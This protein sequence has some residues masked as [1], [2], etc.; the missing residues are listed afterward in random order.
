MRAPPVLMLMVILLMWYPKAP[1]VQDRDFVELFCG[2]MEA[3]LR[4]TSLDIELDPQTMDFL[5]PAGAVIRLDGQYFDRM[6][7][8]N[9]RLSLRAM[10]FQAE[11]LDWRLLDGYVQWAISE[12]TYTLEQRKMSTLQP[13][14]HYYKDSLGVQRRIGKRAEL[15][16]SQN[17]T[18]NFGE[19]LAGAFLNLRAMGKKSAAADPPEV[20]DVMAMLQSKGLLKRGASEAP[21]AERS[22]KELKVE[23]RARSKRK[24]ADAKAEAEKPDEE[25]PP[26]KGKPSKDQAGKNPTEKQEEPNKEQPQEK[27]PSKEKS[28]E[29]PGKPP[30]E[31]KKPS[32]EQSQEKPSKPTKEPKKPSKEQSQ[33]ATKDEASADED[34]GPFEEFPPEKPGAWGEE[35]F[36]TGLN[37]VVSWKNLD[38]VWRACKASD[39]PMYRDM[40]YDALVQMMEKA[41]GARPPTQEEG[42]DEEQDDQEGEEEEAEEDEE[43]EEVEEV[44]KPLPSSSSAKPPPETTS[45]PKINTWN[46]IPSPATKEKARSESPEQAKPT[47][48]N[49]KF[50]RVRRS[51]S[52]QPP[53]LSTLVLG[54]H[55]TDEQAYG[56][57]PASEAGA[58]P[59]E[60]PH[61]GLVSASQAGSDSEL[62]SLV[63]TMQSEITRLKAML[64]TKDAN[65]GA[66]PATPPAAP[67]AAPPAPPAKASVKH[68]Q[69]ESDGEDENGEEHESEEED[70]EEEEEGDEDHETP[71]PKGKPPATTSVAKTNKP[72]GP[73][74]STHR[75]QWMKFGRRMDSK[76]SEFP[77]MTKLWTGSKDEQHEV[78]AKWLEEGE[79]MN[80]TEAQLIITKTKSAEVKSGYEELTVKEMVARGFSATKIESIVRKGG[81][82]DPDAPHCL[83]SIVYVCRKKKNVEESEKVSQTGEIKSKMKAS[84]KA[85]APLMR[86][87]GMPGPGSTSGATDAVLQLAANAFASGSAD[88]TAAAPKRNPKSKA[89][90]KAKALIQ[91][92]KTPKELLDECRKEL[93][94]EYNAANICYDLPKDHALRKD[95]EGKKGDL[96]NRLDELRSV[97]D[98]DAEDFVDECKALVEN[99]RMVRAQVRAV[100][101]ELQ[102]KSASVSQ[103]SLPMLDDDKVVW[104]DWPMILPHNFELR[105][106]LVAAMARHGHLDMLVADW[107]MVPDYW[108]NFLREHPGHPAR[109]KMSDEATA[110]NE[111]WMFLMFTSDLH[112]VI[113]LHFFV[114]GFRGDWKALRQSFNFNRYA[115]RDKAGS[116][117]DFS[118]TTRTVLR[119]A[120]FYH[121]LAIIVIIINKGNP[122]V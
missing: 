85:V 58:V 92:P 37:V 53:S 94:K 119:V 41:L 39:K 76:G 50:N 14:C 107:D 69:K 32:K 21:A 12:A 19:F 26:K 67:P 72:K 81:T 9:F 95:M 8:N 82:P 103:V 24:Q 86:L 23:T 47:D 66:P 121:H 55:L 112:P 89:K 111:T 99:T 46:G 115:D 74:S 71:P 34:L 77:E 63:A 90:A 44:K 106:Q 7:M 54:A 75:A 114:A 11:C 104:R 70:D 51:K 60:D 73:N 27:K 93:K 20:A 120:I 29:K 59:A 87:N 65:P 35:F 25:K 88:A 30:K 117:Q 109:D 40:Q 15:K 79:N 38:D 98:D 118:S 6:E 62:R 102:R 110:V 49:N 64:A 17:Y 113:R 122:E 28:Q 5:K 22:Q 33:D 2:K 4:G 31:P 13:L 105:L 96:E 61:E 100:A 10:C 43:E 80:N 36:E 91:A 3:G 57:R 78:F 52:E 18:R 16:A 108:T 1:C 83:E 48:L 84:A 97:A 45:P 101:A 42:D 68:E 116:T 56:S